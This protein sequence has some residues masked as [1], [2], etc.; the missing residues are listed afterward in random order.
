MRSS[1]TPLELGIAFARFYLE[2]AFGYGNVEFLDRPDEED[3][4]RGQS[5]EL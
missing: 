2:Q 3:T 1:R 5:F 4:Q